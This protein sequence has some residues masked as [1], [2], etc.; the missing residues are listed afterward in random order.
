MADL[1]KELTLLVSYLAQAA[2]TLVIAVA[3]LKAIALYAWSLLRPAAGTLALERNRLSL[4][5]S[6]TLG[7]EFL[8]GADILRTAVAP[9]WTDI[10][11]LAA[12]VAI[13]TALSYFLAYELERAG[14]RRGAA[15]HPAHI[16]GG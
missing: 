5:N 4:G 6:L 14:A 3:V 12:I 8:I 16:S 1:M 2:A 7:L 11:Q 15:E 9:S 13:R 10:G